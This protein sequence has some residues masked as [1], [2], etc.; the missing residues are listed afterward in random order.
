[1]G[2]QNLYE[3]V[4]PPLI[5]AGPGIPRGNSAA[6]VYLFGLFPTICE[7]AG[8]EIPEVVEGKSLLPLIFGKKNKVRDELLGAYRNCQRMVRDD[9]WKLIEYR[10]SGAA[11]T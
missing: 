2:K 6:L 1:M 7:L 9:R 4:K 5:V 8:V 10:A 3:H 11:H